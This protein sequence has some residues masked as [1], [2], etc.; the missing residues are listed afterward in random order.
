[1]RIGEI[2][3]QSGVST[4]TIRYYEDIGVMPRPPRAENGYR[5]YGP[6]AVDRLTFVRDAQDS[7]LTLEEISSV[8][9]LRG[10]GETTC[11]HVIEFLERHLEEVDRRIE[12][13]RESRDVYASLITRARKLEP[14][15]CTDPHRCQT[16]SSGPA[17][18]SAGSQPRSERW[19]RGAGH[20]EPVAPARQA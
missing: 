3:R 13:L 2:A 5:D 12:S 18:R 16:I 14:G 4:Q 7:G 1:M 6:D 17:R 15:D 8:L 10:R 11:E 9:E 19:H 20:A